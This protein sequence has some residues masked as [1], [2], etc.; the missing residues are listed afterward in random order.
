VRHDGT[1]L[2]LAGRRADPG[3]YRAVETDGGFRVQLL[4]AIDQP[5]ALCQH[6]SAPL[7]YALAEDPSGAATVTV[8]S[9]SSAD[10]ALVATVA[11][12]L[13]P[14]PCDVAVSPDGGVLAAV[15]FGRDDPLGD[16]VILRLDRTGLP[17]GAPA[18]RL[19]GMT[20]PHQAVFTGGELYVPDLG[21][22]LVHRYRD[23]GTAFEPRTPLSVP[24]GTGPRHLVVLDEGRA[25]GV[26]TIAISGEL[27]ETV[28][29]GEV[30]GDDVVWASTPS[31][32]RTGPAHSR[33]E[34][35]YPGDIKVVAP[36]RVLVTNRGHDTLGLV[37]VDEPEL[38]LIHE[39][40]L[41]ESW[42]Q[43][44]GVV[45][46]RVFVACWDSDV[47]IEVR[48]DRDTGVRRVGEFPCPGA[49]WVVDGSTTRRS[50]PPIGRGPE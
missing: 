2:L 23:D 30:R 14:I 45:D 19:T 22:D 28:V 26:R 9:T 21:A 39:L 50:E 20:H 36:G 40:D 12:P 4:A 27:G 42:P 25:D 47:V 24:A 15:A 44:I 49:S 38:R 18:Q 46:G 35:N 10:A 33:S 8:W 3:L 11:L 48:I 13:G 16:L 31:T 37:A 7:L 17:T 6:P 5:V 1:A 29:R 43:H 41:P 32:R 34:R